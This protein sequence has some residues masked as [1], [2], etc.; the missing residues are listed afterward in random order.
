MNCTALDET[1]LPTWSIDIASDVVMFPLQ[2]ATQ[3]EDLNAHGLFKIE[4]PGTPSTTVRL[5]I[6]NTVVNNQTVIYC[7]RRGAV[8]TTTLFVISK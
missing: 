8:A 7:N 5:L 2:F 6:N 1:K 4:E 3:D